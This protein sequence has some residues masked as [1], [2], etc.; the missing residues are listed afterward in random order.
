MAV[1][2]T[3]AALWAE[4][5][6]PS[7]VERVGLF[8]VDRKFLVLG[9]LEALVRPSSSVKITVLGG[10]VPHFLRLS[11]STFVTTR[12]VDVVMVCFS[13]FI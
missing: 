13:T 8:S 7:S 9:N 4:T 2:G 5:T 6:M 10:V 12:G 11:V 1:S 3:S